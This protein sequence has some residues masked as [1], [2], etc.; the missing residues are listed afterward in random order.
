[1]LILP[2][3]SSRYSKTDSGNKN[4]FINILYMFDL[5]PREMLK[6]YKKYGL[7]SYF[8]PIFSTTTAPG[9]FFSFQ[10]TK[11]LYVD[12]ASAKFHKV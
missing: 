9:N 4:S 6:K 12:N 5:F 3:K 10:K 11:I 1:M 2:P 8:L 7:F